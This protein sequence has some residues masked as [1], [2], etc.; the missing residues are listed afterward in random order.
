MYAFF[1]S[2]LVF[3]LGNVS[4]NHLKKNNVRSLMVLYVATTFIL[5]AAIFIQYFGLGY[6]LS[7]KLYAYSSKNSVSQIICS[8]IL[9]LIVYFRPKKLAVKCL[10]IAILVFEVYVLILLRSRATLVSLI[11]CVIIMALSNNIRRGTKV[12]IVLL[13]MT[14]IVLLL[15]SKSFYNTVFN[16]ILFAGRDSSDLNELTSGRIVMVSQ[17]PE[18]IRGHWMDGIGSVYYESFPLS[19]V[20]QFGLLGGMT[21][22]GISLTPLITSMK[23]RSVSTAWLLLFYVA[24][25]FTVNGLF[26]GLTPFGPGI[27]CFFMWF[28]YGVLLKNDY[29]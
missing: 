8:T 28:L 17:F 23:R 15:A 7:T 29:A 14:T 18:L 11:L 20:L 21:L 24:V 27:K 26:E 3:G 6:S 12:T 22:I 5:T 13:G 10:R 25:G 2:L 1:I 16:N 9:V 4:A 19:S